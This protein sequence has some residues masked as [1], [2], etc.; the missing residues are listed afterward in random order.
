MG[1]QK[2]VGKTLP[3]KT[4]T[5]AQ[6]VADAAAN[7][8]ARQRLGS[9]AADHESKGITAMKNWEQ[10]KQIFIQTEMNIFLLVQDA[11]AGNTFTM[12]MG[13]RTTTAD[14][15]GGS[16]NGAKKRTDDRKGKRT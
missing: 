4:K 11:G 6:C 1:G 5:E 15:V 7:Q 12:R 13:I 3:P 16:L 9:L 10:K 2:T 14:S 8:I